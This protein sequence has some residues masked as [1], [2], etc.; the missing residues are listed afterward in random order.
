IT[1]LLKEVNSRTKI[2][3]NKTSDSN[4][5]I[6]QKSH[7]QT[8][9]R[10]IFTGHK[11]SSNESFAVY[12]KTSPKS[13]LRWKPTGRIFKSVGF[14][15]LP[16]GKLFDSCTSK[17]EREPTNGFN[18][19]ISNIHECKQTLDLSAGK[20]QSLVTAKA[21]ISETNAK[22]DSQMMKSVN[23][24]KGD[25]CIFVGY[26]TQSRAYRVFN[27]RTRVIMESI[28][29][30]F[31]EL[32]QMASAHNSSDPA[33]TCQKMA[34][35]QI[36]SDPAPECQTM[37]VSK[38]SAVSAA[39]APNQRQQ[40]T[41]PLNNHTTPAPTCQNPSIESSVTS[42]ENI[43]QAEPHA[44]DDQVADDEFINIFSTPVQ[45]QGETSLHHSM[46]LN[47]DS[48]SPAIQ[49]QANVPHTDRTVKTSNELDLLFS[50][51][52]DEL[53]NGSSKV[54]SKSSVVCSANAPNQRHHHT[55]S[56]NN[57]TT[58]AP[59]CQVPTLVPTVSSSENINQA[60]T[61]A[62]NDQVADDEFI[63]IFSTLQVIGNPSQSVRTRRQLESNAKMCMFALTVS[64]SKPKNIKEAM[65][66]SAWIESMQEELHQF[67]R[68]DIW[69]LVDRP[70]CTNV[71]NL[72]WL[73]KNKRD[74]ENTVI[75]NKSCLVAKGYAQKE[76]VDFVESFA[77]VARLEAVRLFI[78]YVAH[79]SFTV[80]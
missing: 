70:L 41:T 7:T 12:K 66:D 15:W 42:N 21:D 6:D 13:D 31:N 68:L 63:N 54:V 16:T 4:N 8:P 3:S 40:P 73:W 47:H 45:D 26:S 33:P 1:K 76:G 65:A 30:N 34:S 46:A 36:S 59:T 75:R 32:P 43:T 49:R 74:E 11:F 57:H 18:T 14:R 52:F 10:Q 51:I 25:E 56:L 64:R 28:H 38:S 48:L 55:T 27:K 72:K 37:V 29:V 17:V 79:K 80:Y 2:Q 53:L 71:I 22:V 9:G 60:E 39:D 35:V 69:E 78:A 62:E 19:D 50:L 44:K 20:S 67:D 61:Y 23:G 24:E 58:L 5:P 77:R